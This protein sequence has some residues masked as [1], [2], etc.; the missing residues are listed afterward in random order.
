MRL[1][2][3][4]MSSWP[5]DSKKASLVASLSE[6][7]EAYATM[8]ETGRRS[9]MAWKGKWDDLKANPTPCFHW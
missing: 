8:A 5:T 6:S 9:K 4:V 2:G 3:T 1:T 7:V